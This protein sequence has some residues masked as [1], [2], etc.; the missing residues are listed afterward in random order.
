MNKLIVILLALMLIVI[1]TGIVMAEEEITNTVTIGMPQIVSDSVAAHGEAVAYDSFDVQFLMGDFINNGELTPF[2]VFAGE[3]DG[4]AGDVVGDGGSNNAVWRWQWRGAQD[5]N[6]LL[7]FTAR[8]PMTLAVTFPA[9]VKN[10]WATHT[11]YAYFKEDTAANRELLSEHPVTEVIPAG[12]MNESVELAVGESFY[13]VYYSTNE[14]N[15]TSDYCPSILVTTA[16]PAKNAFNKVQT[17]GMPQIVSDAV[18]AKGAEVAY[19]GVTAQFL[20]GDFVNGG[21]MTPFTVFAGDGDGGAGDV[22]GDGGSDNAVWRWQWRGAQSAN[23]VLKLTA[24][25]WTVVSVECADKQTGQWAMHTKYAY[26]KEGA[27][28]ERKLISEHPVTEIIEAGAMNAEAKLAPNESLYIVYYSTN[29]Y[30]GTSNYNPTVKIATVGEAVEEKPLT[31]ADIVSASVAAKGEA[32]SYDGADVQFLKGDFINHGE[33][34][35]FTTFAGDGSGSAGDLVGDGDS[36]NAVWRWQW[37]A[38][39]AVNT[40]LRITATKNIRLALICPNDVKDQWAVHSVYAYYTEGTEGIQALVA[41]HPVTETV[42]A[43]EMDAEVHLRKGDSFYIVYYTTDPTGNVTSGYVPQVIIDPDGYS[44]KLRTNYTGNDE[45]TVSDMISDEVAAQGGVISYNNFDAQ[46]LMGDF[47]NHGELQPFT[48]FAGDG[49]GSAGDV[50]GDGNSDNALW[51]W[52]W[53]GVDKANTILKIVATE[54]IR[55]TIDQFYKETSQWATHTLY[56]Y[57]VESPEGERLVLS[58]FRVTETIEAGKMNQVIHLA[59]GDVFYIVYYSTNSYNGTSGYRPN[60]I[61]EKDAYDAAQRTDFAVIAAL[62]KA[63]DETTETLEG[64][65]AEM[66]GDGTIYAEDKADQLKTFVSSTLASI[67]NMGSVDS[68]IAAREETS[69][70]MDQVHT[71]AQDAEILANFK[72]E[73]KKQIAESADKKDYTGKNWAVI[74][75]IIKQANADIDA[76]VRTADVNT[77]TTK[78]MYSIKQIELKEPLPVGLIAGIAGGALVVIAAVILIIVK[79]KKNGGKKTRK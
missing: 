63:I 29:E 74:E 51:R 54:N 35:P 38:S 49:S 57:V 52:Q 72:A 56:A 64:K 8:E 77:V 61:A 45:V 6:T 69:K 62:R 31:T 21:E 59:K 37:R 1:P 27:D 70:K 28:G 24:A 9:E 19:E 66:L 3:G 67:G 25:E 58:E 44:K 46:F 10:Q 43:G 78:A 33:L 11:K 36:D 53:R 4:G 5:A 16:G 20:M 2:T 50:V 71:I 60:I 68:I 17:V 48:V 32:V 75:G 55:L 12:T 73:C 30:N 22:V 23:T 79:A 34:T 7:K 13:I 76:A 41:E 39:N 40:V 26:Y 14:Y 18:A 65:L 42:P 47:F 15:G